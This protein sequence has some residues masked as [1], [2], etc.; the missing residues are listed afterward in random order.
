MK[1]NPFKI[2][3][4]VETPYFMNRKKE[5]NY[6]QS[7]L[8]SQNHLV[9]LGP[10][11]YGKTSLIT[12]VLS[13]INR[14]S[15]VIDMQIVLSEEE[16]AS[17]I[18]KKL[19]SYY[20]GKKFNEL[21]KK[22]RIMP[23]I[24]INAITNEISLSF[25]VSNNDSTVILEDVFSI[26]DKLSNS[27]DKLIIVFDEFQEIFEISKNLDKKLRSIMQ[28][29]KNV[30]YVFLGSQESLM[31]Y[32]F[33]NKKS[34]FYHFCEML[35][36]DKIPY[37][38]W[39]NYICVCFEEIVKNPQQL[40]DSILKFT[41]CH[42]YYTQQ[43]A[44]NIW[45]LKDNNIPETDLIDECKQDIIKR[46][47]MD[48]ERLYHTLKRTDM[49]VLS[50]LAEG[51]TNIMDSKSLTKIN[52]PSSTAFSSLKRL[53]LKGLLVVTNKGYEIDDPFFKEWLREKR[54][55]VIVFA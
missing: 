34:P 9:I 24:S 18:L 54:Q 15:I 26:I 47:D 43:L 16:L 3:T 33:E 38:E 27:K 2:G 32:I 12:K 10:R 48:F 22:F 30:N 29:H 31:K 17:L 25:N 28:Y 55:Q 44:Y 40:A 50:L 14:K 5:I 46:H 53:A 41:E 39:F 49:K 52:L 19:Y 51:N 8:N 45:T 6:I 23:Q 4:V 35:N 13:E 20:K 36:L 42:P 37:T 1:I 11:R 21:V 7:I